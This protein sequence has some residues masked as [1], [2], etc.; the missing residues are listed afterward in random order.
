MKRRSE[1]L[2]R[3]R[4]GRLE[5]LRTTKLARSVHMAL[6][7]VGVDEDWRALEIST[8]VL[9]GL[10]CRQQ[11]PVGDEPPVLTT[12]E[13]STAV[14]HVLVATGH[15]AAAVP[16]DAVAIERLR[17]RSVM[18][19]SDRGIAINEGLAVLPQPVDPNNRLPRE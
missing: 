19:S 8:A 6:R 12:Q 9:A 16:F 2:V 7:S 17:R 4:D 5:F 10:R 1:H 3:K 13:L 11:E 15:P 14:Q 18:A